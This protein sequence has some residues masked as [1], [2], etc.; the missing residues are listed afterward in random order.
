MA[1]Q[2]TLKFLTFNIRGPWDR[3]PNSWEN[4]R[5]GVAAL[6]RQENP[7]VFGTQEGVQWQLDEM[8][9]AL[10]E[11]DRIGVGRDDGHLL[12]EQCAIWFRRDTF[13][14]VESQTFWLS[15]S[16]D[17]SASMSWQTACTRICTSAHLQ[18]AFGWFRVYNCHTDHMS[19]EARLKGVALILERMKMYREPSVL[20]GDFN[21]GE[22]S[23]PIQL[24]AARGL[25]DTFRSINPT[26]QDVATYTDFNPLKTSGEKIDYI[27]CDDS[28][29]VEDAQIVR[30][31]F[32]QRQPSDHFP[33]SATLGLASSIRFP[34]IGKP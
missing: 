18:G 31:T 23:K 7:H 17:V 6:I 28:F 21:A 1:G 32:N 22:T 12:G 34:S 3:G 10:P 24:A 14:L 19:A 8:A 33:V 5:A 15:E 20:M 30:T 13:R 11:W 29:R 25:K 4:R 26:A 16:P 2:V 27:F 9:A